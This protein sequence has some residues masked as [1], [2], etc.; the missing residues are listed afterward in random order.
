MKG[1]LAMEKPWIKH[2]DKGVPAVIDFP[3]EPKQ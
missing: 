2:Y 3:I 1:V